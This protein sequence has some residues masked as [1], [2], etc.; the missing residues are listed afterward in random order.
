MARRFILTIDVGTSSTK[1]ALWDDAGLC[2]AEASRA[3]ALARPYPTWAEIDGR[4][5]W[6]AVCAATRQ[7]VAQSRID[8]RAVAGIG[9]DGVGWTLLPVDRHGEPLSPAM[10][11][12][13]RRAEAEARQLASGP[14]GERLVALAANPIDAAYVTPKLLWLKANRP[15]V[16]DAANAFLTCSGFIVSRLTGRFTCDF[17][18]AYGYHF[19]DIRRER[20]CETTA[21]AL[22]VPLEK[23]PRLAS[24]T[25]VAGELRPAAAA[26][27]GLTAGAP[28]IVGCLDAAVGALG[29][30]VTRNGQTNEQGGQAG[31]MA[32]SLGQ[33]VVE[34][35]LIFSH[36]V[37][38]G[39]YLLQGGTVGGGLLG[40]FR[41]VLGLADETDSQGVFE[42][43]SA[44]AAGSS[45]GARGLIFIPYMAGERTPLWNSDARGVFLGLTYSTSRGDMV[46]AI[47]EGCA[48]AVYDNVAVASQHGLEVSEYLGSGG[49][50]RSDVW[51]Q[52]KAD[53]YG[54]P[55]CLA[56]RGDG[57]EG[58]HALGLY[59][60]TA[61]AVGLSGSAAEH[62]ERLLPGRRV[63]EP[64][65]PHHA[66]YRELFEV[67]RSASR[68]L[69]AEFEELEAIRQRRGR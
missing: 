53:V 6:D 4:L 68:K 16:F 65:L 17:T 23:M 43:L 20:W 58:G 55:F 5:W 12:L 40:W 35:R 14:E 24:A 51:C 30:G 69:L 59:A 28:V 46:R 60:L 27:M 11:W 49:A 18:Q 2:V 41:D 1:T 31:G 48:F 21:A 37:L 22:G 47:M 32:I 50:T 52:I 54:R 63:F 39:Q 15:E 57:G 8:P 26:A 45:P 38:P 29:A 33:V 67:Y 66:L 9:V 10:I 34:R 64:S 56:R 7:L 3:Y 42:A 62:V 61:Q 25:D 13:D 19:F 36:H 44:Q